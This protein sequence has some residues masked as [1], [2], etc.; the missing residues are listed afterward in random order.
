MVSFN[1]CNYQRHFTPVR[2]FKHVITM[3]HFLHQDQLYQQIHGVVKGSTLLPAIA[4]FYL[5]R[6]FHQNFPA[7]SGL[8]MT[9]LSSDPMV[10]KHFLPFCNISITFTRTQ[11]SLRRQKPKDLCLFWTLQLSRVQMGSSFSVSNNL[12]VRIYT[13]IPVVTTM[14]HKNL[15]C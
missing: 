2:L 5:K 4:S 10:W 6:M 3:T 7:F 13:C 15:Q 14:R 8:L 9:C 11:S 1:D 12:H